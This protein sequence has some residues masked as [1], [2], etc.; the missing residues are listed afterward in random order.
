[1]PNV[2]V[3]PARPLVLHQYKLSG[4]CHRVELFLSLLGLPYTSVDVDLPNRAHKAPDFLRMNAFGQVP[5]L[6][7]GDITVPDSNAILV[8]LASRYDP[9]A[10]WL[11]ND[12]ARA[13]AVQRWLSVAA[14]QLAS[15]PAAA[16]LVT[17]FGAPYNAADLIA[18]SN[19][20]FTVMEA[21]LRSRPF[22]AGADPT[23]AD[24]ANYSYTVLAPEGN[25][26]LAPYPNLRA[27]LARIE[28]LPG[29]LPAPRSRVGLAA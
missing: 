29:F 1:M 8:Y 27:W 14:G 22:L 12:P 13:A 28:D 18:R 23:L 15:G 3:R 4:H 19:A 9:D 10:R 16:R 21:E 6:Q 25:V 26:D 17:L 24:V 20:L 2:A 11:P 5:V 7:D